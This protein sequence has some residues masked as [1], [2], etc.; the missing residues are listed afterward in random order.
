MAHHVYLCVCMCVCVR[1]CIFIKNWDCDLRAKHLISFTRQRS[2]SPKAVTGNISEK[3]FSRSRRMLNV[4]L[5]C[6]Y[7]DNCHVILIRCYVCLCIFV[8]VGIHMHIHAPQHEAFCF[9]R[10][11]FLHY[12]AS[13]FGRRDKIS[14]SQSFDFQYLTERS[15]LDFLEL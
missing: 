9:S 15:T 5:Y 2:K 14:N 8:Y 1:V 13:Q 3:G 10:V 11:L 12:S 6:H 7:A 4:M